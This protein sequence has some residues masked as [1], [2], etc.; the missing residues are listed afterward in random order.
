MDLRKLMLFIVLISGCQSKPDNTAPERNFYF[1]I[2]SNSSS[3]IAE[4]CRLYLEGAIPSHKYS[5]TNASGYEWPYYESF[6]LEK[7]VNKES[8][9]PPH[10]FIHK[11]IPFNENQVINNDEFYV[12]ID[13]FVQADTLPN[14]RVT[15]FRK[16]DNAL[17]LSGTSGMHFI[18]SNEFKSSDDLSELFL[19]SILRYSFK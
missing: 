4:K 2:K 13:I 16:Q 10:F 11:M 3:E 7:A 6:D 15:I 14:Y 18:Q 1:K 8:L 12:E 19:K 9:M 5:I 17:E